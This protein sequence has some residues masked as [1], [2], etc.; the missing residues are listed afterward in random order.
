MNRILIAILVALSLQACAPGKVET[1]LL[2]QT[3]VDKRVE[4]LSIVFR[5][6]EKPEYSENFLKTYVGS[7]EQYFGKYK[8][9]ELIQFTKSII[10]EYGIAF[11]GPMWMAMHLDDNLNLLADVKDVWQHDPRWT[12]ENVDKF[13]PLL[14]QFYKD[15]QFD[16]FFKDNADLYAEAVKRFSLLYEQVDLNW[17]YSFY[18]EKSSDLFLIKIGL[19]V[20]GN[21]FGVNVDYNDGTRKVYAIMGVWSIDNT[22]M[23][24]FAKIPDLPIVMHEFSHPFIDNL[25]A[26][27]ME[28]FQESGE[29]IYSVVRN[30]KGYI[31]DAEAYPSWEVIFDEAL[32]HAATIKYMKDHDFK[33][34]EVDN[35]MKWMKEGF[36]FFWMEE[37]V[38][39]LENYDKQRDKYPTLE[40]YMP[41]LAEAYKIWVENI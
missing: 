28:A 30:E 33:P 31:M 41:K 18:G 6:A 10:D 19:G 38:A 12:K 15:T 36:G 37:L 22:G 40:S 23:P 34:S 4:L 14:K 29:R 8:N 16:E 13:I 26:K 2:E 27:K 21:C 25:T 7:I 24:V 35:W 20:W 1:V 5:L 11:D 17:L 39:E 3:G 9:H 32:T